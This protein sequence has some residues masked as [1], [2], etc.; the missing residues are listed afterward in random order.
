M[1]NNIQ[2]II[3]LSKVDSFDV[4][5]FFLTVSPSK[6]VSTM[7]GWPSYK[8]ETNYGL[9]HDYLNIVI[10]ITIDMLFAM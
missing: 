8:N 9:Y 10:T 1:I 6:S 3:T 7:Y 4:N 2:K 5:S